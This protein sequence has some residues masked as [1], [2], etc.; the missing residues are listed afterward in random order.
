MQIM[1]KGYF[2]QL[3]NIHFESAAGHPDHWEDWEIYRQELEVSCEQE[4]EGLPN[5]V[6]PKISV[7]AVEYGLNRLGDFKTKLHLLGDHSNDVLE[8]LK[9]AMPARLRTA[10]RASQMSICSCLEKTVGRASFSISGVA[11]CVSCSNLCSSSDSSLQPSQES[12][13]DGSS[14]S[15][16]PNTEGY[17]REDLKAKYSRTQFISEF[18]DRLR[19]YNL[20]PS[21]FLEINLQLRNY[22]PMILS[23]YYTI[24][25]I[26]LH[27]YRLLMGVFGGRYWSCRVKVLYRLKSGWHLTRLKAQVNLSSFKSQPF[28]FKYS[29]LQGTDIFDADLHQLLFLSKLLRARHFVPKSILYHVST[30]ANMI[31]RVHQN[32][33]HR[34][35]LSNNTP[36]STTLPRQLEIS[37]LLALMVM[38][39]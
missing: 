16:R 39:L 18:G 32:R 24:S 5:W 14:S 22:I 3:G 36:P 6:Q 20:S 31:A 30:S 26:N 23:S 11:L 34:G 27:M 7:M 35:C 25:A 28:F 12:G 4:K 29:S 8:P 15:K 21:A 33:T 38:V 2:R 10:T 1:S 9:T 37:P 13:Q 19:L 17:H